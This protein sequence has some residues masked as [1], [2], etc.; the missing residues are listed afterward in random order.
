MSDRRDLSA[1]RANAIAMNWSEFEVSTLLSSLATAGSE[2]WEIGRGTYAEAVR[3][4]ESFGSRSVLELKAKA[5]E[6]KCEYLDRGVEVPAE[7]GW[8][9]VL[10]PRQG[11]RGALRVLGGG[12]DGE[13][14]IAGEEEAEAS[15]D[16]GEGEEWEVAGG[17]EGRGVNVA[18]PVP[19]AGARL[20]EDSRGV[21]VRRD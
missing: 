16:D 6:L 13:G 8:V 18:L 2:Q 21:R 12:E 7:L 19:A 5:K 14:S 15:S 9:K 17:W 3:K 1:L 4:T 10:W 20:V 11:Y